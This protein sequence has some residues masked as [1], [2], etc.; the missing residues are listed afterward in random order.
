M[1][2]T[3]GPRYTTR[4]DEAL[5]FVA[6]A[7]RHQVRK[8]SG[9]P[10]LSHLLAV[11]ATVAEHGGDEDQMIAALCHDYLE[12]IEGAHRG[13][14]E[15]RFGARVAELVEGLSDATVQPKPPWK[16]RKLAY[17]ARLRREPEELKLISA[18]DK[19]HNAS[20]I[21]RD[22]RRV[23]E[24]VWERFTA[25]R[26][27]TLWYYREVLSSLRHEWEH[28]LLD[29]LVAVV[30]QLHVEVGEPLED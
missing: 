18:A 23:G 27:Q 21:L 11:A 24:V 6:A 28:P 12:D 3:G 17:L 16:Q 25:S 13:V 2:A 9:V 20:A 22:H 29:E 8:G 10:Y 5:T 7:F 1:P 26:E 15:Q 30:R 14:L 19:L 4:L